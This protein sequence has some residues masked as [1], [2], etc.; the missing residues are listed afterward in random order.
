MNPKLDNSSEGWTQAGHEPVKIRQG[1]DGNNF[2]VATMVGDR[3]IAT[4]KFHL[5]VDK[6]YTFSGT[7][8]FQISVFVMLIR[9]IRYFHKL[10]TS[11]V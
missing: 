3:I 6:L 5:E 7:D 10:R 4:Q 11:H 8:I 9:A 1:K 2:L